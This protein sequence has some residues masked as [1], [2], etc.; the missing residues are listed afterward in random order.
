MRYTPQHKK[1]K[2][3][4]PTVESQL[5]CK[6]KEKKVYETEGEKIYC[7][8]AYCHSTMCIFL[9]ITMLMGYHI[10]YFLF[11]MHEWAF[12]ETTYVMLVERK[13]LGIKKKIFSSG[14]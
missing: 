1:L 4:Q 7:N 12:V 6:M 9:F 2:I 5:T 8:I 10:K 14:K 11:N 13:E 3:F